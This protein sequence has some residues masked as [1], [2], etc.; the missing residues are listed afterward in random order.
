LSFLKATISEQV[1]VEE[2]TPLMKSWDTMKLNLREK[3]ELK[4]EGFGRLLVK[5][6]YMY[7]EQPRKQRL[8]KGAIRLMKNSPVK[9]LRK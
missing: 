7:V 3:Y 4:I 1:I 5:E 6:A 2:Q 9:Y 8:T